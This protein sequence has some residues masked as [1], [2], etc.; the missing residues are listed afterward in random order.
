MFVIYIYRT[1]YSSKGVLASPSWPGYN[2]YD[3]CASWELKARSDENI[4]LQIMDI[5][6]TSVHGCDE[7]V[8]HL[9]IKGKHAAFSSEQQSFGVYLVYILLMVAVVEFCGIQISPQA[10]IHS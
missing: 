7:Y 8:S 10:E 3:Q 5:K 6:Y 2:S 9:A 1:Y 4:H